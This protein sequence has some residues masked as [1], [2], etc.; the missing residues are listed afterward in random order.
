MGFA[1]AHQLSAKG[2]NVIL[3][4]RSIPKL[5][6]A[7][8]AVR[9]AARNPSTQRFHYISADVSTPS[10][11]TAVIAEAT[12]WNEG[13]S[14]DIVWCVAGTASPELFIDMDMTSMR[15]QMD[16]N[17]FGTAEMAHA[18]LKEWLAPEAPVENQPRHLIMT[19][20]AIVFFPISGY[21]PYAPTKWAVRGL[22]DTIS[23]EVMLYPQNVKLHVVCPG[24]IL[25]PG[26]ERENKTKPEI[27]KILEEADPQQTPDEVAQR[28]IQGLE[29]GD[30]LVTVNWLG[31][32]MKWG[33]LGGSMRNN[34]LI[35]TFMAGVILLVWPLVHFD[36]FGKTRS[37]GKKHGHP[38]TWTKQS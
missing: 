32:I 13:R 22:A 17:Y 9:A 31:G 18:V 19:T 37:Y 27:T 34:W 12:T 1:A 30:Y 10:Y 8:E 4:S 15:R 11:A 7:L 38:S 26:F 21:A 5:Q 29:N 24:T 23:Q 14:P 25:S 3:V 16:I 2:A 20:S 35:D 28:S 36:T 6:T 33:A